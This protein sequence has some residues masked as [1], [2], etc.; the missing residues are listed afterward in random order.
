MWMDRLAL[1]RMK[2]NNAE[3]EA[4]RVYQLDPGR[5]FHANNQLAL[6]RISRVKRRGRE[7]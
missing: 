4:N 2:L 5:H 7:I 3:G 1:S 6:V